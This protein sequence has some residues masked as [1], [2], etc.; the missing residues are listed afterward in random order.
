MDKLEKLRGLFQAEEVDS[1]IEKVAIGIW[2]GA[3]NG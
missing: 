1:P 2:M 3:V